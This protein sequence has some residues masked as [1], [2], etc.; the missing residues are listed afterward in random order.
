MLADAECGAATSTEIVA[1]PA[2]RRGLHSDCACDHKGS[3]SAQI[4]NRTSFDFKGQTEVEKRKL[5]SGL[6]GD[7]SPQ[8]RPEAALQ[9]DG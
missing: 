6:G 3:H 2:L 1:T 9:Q 8:A 4:R 7:K 5:L